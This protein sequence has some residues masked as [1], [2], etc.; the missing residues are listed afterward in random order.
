MSSLKEDLQYW[1]KK[2]WLEE[3]VESLRALYVPEEGP[4]AQNAL[5][6][7]QDQGMTPEEYE[8]FHARLLGLIKEVNIKIDFCIEQEGFLF[9]AC[10]LSAISRIGHDVSEVGM[11]GALLVKMRE[12]KI[13][14]AEN[15]FDFLTLYENLG[16]L[17][18]NTFE[19]CLSGQKICP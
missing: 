19:K 12:G 7:G 1:F 15:Y 4:S 6:L 10:T 2:V 3:D 13:L 16:L 8:V 5:G 18:K 17:P 14:Y 11:K 9:A